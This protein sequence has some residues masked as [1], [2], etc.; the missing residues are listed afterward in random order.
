MKTENEMT[1]YGYANG[2]N[3]E[4]DAAFDKCMALGYKLTL[5]QGMQKRIHDRHELVGTGVARQ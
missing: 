4:R 2:Y 5:L 1:D 3:P